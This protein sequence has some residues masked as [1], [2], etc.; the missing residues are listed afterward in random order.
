[1]AIL[2]LFSGNHRFIGHVLAPS[3]KGLTSW[4]P[5]FQ[6]G[7][8]KFKIIHLLP[9][10]NEDNN[11]NRERNNTFLHFLLCR[12][13]GC[14]NSSCKMILESRGAFPGSPATG[15]LPGTAPWHIGTQGGIWGWHTPWDPPLGQTPS[16]GLLCLVWLREVRAASG[17][18][19]F[20]SYLYILCTPLNI[21]MSMPVCIYMWA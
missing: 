8:K 14:G 12:N 18:C 15:W 11:F 20:Y 19:I 13:A 5:D 9:L 17:N 10:S 6:W 21:Y 7:K 4:L 3:L 2:E 16:L 1:M